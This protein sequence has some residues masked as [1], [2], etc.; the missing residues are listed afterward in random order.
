MVARRMAPF[1]PI[2]YL[3]LVSSEYCCFLPSSSPARSLEALS[4]HLV[5]VSVF[6]GPISPDAASVW[7]MLARLACRGSNGEALFDGEAE[8]LPRIVI[9]IAWRNGARLALAPW[10][11]QRDL[12]VTQHQEPQ[13][14][15]VLVHTEYR[16]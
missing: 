6:L 2:M 11:T 16:P 4:A 15:T 10:Q 3:I 13:G 5:A 12:L 9:I 8:R 7:T 1:H 14:H